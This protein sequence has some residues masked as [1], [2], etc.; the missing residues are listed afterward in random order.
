MN[1]K[2]SAA[3]LA[4]S[5]LGFSGGSLFAIPCYN[6]DFT[7]CPGAQLTWCGDECEDPEDDICAHYVKEVTQ[8]W[9][10]Y[11]CSPVSMT[12]VEWGATI[13]Q[14]IG[15]E[16]DHCKTWYSCDIGTTPCEYGYLCA[17]GSATPHYTNRSKGV[18][19]GT[20]CNGA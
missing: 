20:L 2:V 1:A 12:E 3:V 11:W 16:S 15:E 17:R 13:C 6:N 4:I 8:I 7:S 19:W 5:L 14:D 9:E 10:W 18:K